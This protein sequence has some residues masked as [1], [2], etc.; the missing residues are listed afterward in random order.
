MAGVRKR[1]AAI[2]AIRSC[3]PS[4]ISLYRD[5]ARKATGVDW[6]FEEIRTMCADEG[7]D[8]LTVEQVGHMYGFNRFRIT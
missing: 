2:K 5:R 7:I 1:R 4:C 8:V 6:S 3:A